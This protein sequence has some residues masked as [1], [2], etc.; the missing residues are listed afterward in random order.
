M[1]ATTAGLPSPNSWA[2]SAPRFNERALSEEGRPAPDPHVLS[3]G[4]AGFPGRCKRATA[5]TPNSDKR[6]HQRNQPAPPVGF[7]R[8]T[9]CASRRCE[10]QMSRALQRMNKSARA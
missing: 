1:S 10:G 7:G 4:V 9:S 3:R 6:P 8:R 5:S 2:T